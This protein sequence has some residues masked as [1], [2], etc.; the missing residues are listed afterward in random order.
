MRSL[1]YLL[2]VPVTT[3]AFG[4][5]FWLL[6]LLAPYGLPSP[7]EPPSPPKI[8]TYQTGVASWYGRRY[9]GRT[10]TY[11]ETYD[12]NA[13]TTAHRYLPYNTIVHVTNLGNGCKTALRVTDTG[14]FPGIVG[15]DYFTESRVLDVSRQGAKELCF[16]REGKA[17]VEIAV[18]TGF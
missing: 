16:L 8:L 14:P 11:G 18:A 10:T 15:K 1:F 12:M 3:V 9:H 17:L 2:Q 5:V 6:L 7:P 4:L 13:S